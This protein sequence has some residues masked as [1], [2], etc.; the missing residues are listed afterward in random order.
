V[1]DFSISSISKVF[2]LSF[3]RVRS[4]T[5]VVFDYLDISFDDY[6]LSSNPYLTHVEFKDI[7][8]NFVSQHLFWD[9]PRLQMLELTNLYDCTFY[10]VLDFKSVFRRTPLGKLGV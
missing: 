5:R 1:I 8:F 7:L 9:C 2:D 3:S 6:A 10:S 4:I